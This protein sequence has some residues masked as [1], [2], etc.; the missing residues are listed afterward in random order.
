MSILV[1]RNNELFA[2]DFHGKDFFGLVKFLHEKYFSEGSLTEHL[3]DFEVAQTYPFGS[4]RV[5]QSLS[6]HARPFVI[7]DVLTANAERVA[8]IT[9]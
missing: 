8:L 1:F 9:H 2:Q 5:L 4:V 6:R 3:E 7:S